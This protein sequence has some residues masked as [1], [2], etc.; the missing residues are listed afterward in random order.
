MEASWWRRHGSELRIFGIIAAFLA[1]VVVLVNWQRLFPPSLEGKQVVDLYLPDWMVKSTE[2]QGNLAAYQENHADVVIRTHTIKPADLVGLPAGWMR[3]RPGADVVVAPSPV[4]RRWAKANLLAEWEG[5][6][7]MQMVPEGFVEAFLRSGQVEG[8]Q[9]LIPITGYPVLVAARKGAPAFP[10]LAA[11]GK[12][13]AVSPY[14]NQ[15]LLLQAAAWAQGLPAPTP[16]VETWLEGHQPVGKPDYLLTQYPGDT[17][18]LL[19]GEVTWSL[20]AAGRPVAAATEGLVIPK[21]NRHY[22]L[23]VQLARD[24]LVLPKVVDRKDWSKGLPVQVRQYRALKGQFPGPL[25]EGLQAKQPAAQ[26]AG[27]GAGTP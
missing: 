13:L 19:G 3:D 27:A 20:P 23:C 6:F 8:K 15:E 22:A 17:G 24:F 5:F 21:A 4:A 10:G 25:L 7:D 2:L 16:A 12:R 26:P 9:Y 14:D 18:E 11:A 1:V